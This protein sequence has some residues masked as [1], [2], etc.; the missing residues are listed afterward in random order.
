MTKFELI[1]FIF[2]LSGFACGFYCQFKARN[3]ISKEKIAQLKDISI[4]ANGPM[5]PKEI[6]SD[7]GLKYYKGF[8]IGATI[9]VASMLLL[10]L[11]KAVNPV[12][13]Q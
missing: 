3:Y 13:A 12:T 10:T 9:F 11:L 7:E 4:I 5:P 1:I 6:L 2:G 8:C